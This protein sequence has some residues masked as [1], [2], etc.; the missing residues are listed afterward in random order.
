MFSS[1]LGEISTQTFSL[2]FSSKIYMH[3]QKENQARE[4]FNSMKIVSRSGCNES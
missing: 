4:N 2:G 1:L 3:I